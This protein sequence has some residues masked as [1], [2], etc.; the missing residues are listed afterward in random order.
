MT[1]QNLNAAAEILHVSQEL[2]I[3][4][5]AEEY[6]PL[7][8]VEVALSSFLTHRLRKL[9]EDTNFEAKIKAALEARIPEAD[10]NQLM[11]L[12]AIVQQN[13]NLG[14]EKVLTPFLN[15][16]AVGL[17]SSRR[18]D[19]EEQIFRGSSQGLL[20]G[21]EELNRLV[22]E[23]ARIKKSSAEEIKEAIATPPPVSN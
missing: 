23:I 16:K 6:S 21:F 1:E 2:A 20:Q 18:T 3:Q 22:S 19:T 8:A 10:I 14:V 17:D 7:V 11:S 9:Q 4:P 5:E 15:N 13:N 12:L